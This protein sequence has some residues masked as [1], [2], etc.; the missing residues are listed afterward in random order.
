MLFITV[1]NTFKYEINNV[2]IILVSFKIVFA[3][4]KIVKA[5][6]EK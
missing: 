5:V 2:Y 3:L 1:N 6:I 4:G